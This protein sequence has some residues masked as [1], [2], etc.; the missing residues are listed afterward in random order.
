[1]QLGVHI[2]NYNTGQGRRQKFAGGFPA[3]HINAH[4]ALAQGRSGGIPHRKMLDFRPSEI[5]SAAFFE[6]RARILQ[7]MQTARNALEA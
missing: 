2:A 6:Y 4:V 3:A 7:I 1:M 5:V